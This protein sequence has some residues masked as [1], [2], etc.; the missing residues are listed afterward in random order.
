MFRLGFVRSFNMGSKSAAKADF[1]NDLSTPGQLQPPRFETLS[2]GVN[3]NRNSFL[4]ICMAVAVLTAATAAAAQGPTR[5]RDLVPFYEDVR[6]GACSTTMSD[7]GLITANTPP[8]T[9][10]FNRTFRGQPD[11]H[12]CDPILNP[13]N[14]QMTL[15]QYNAV[16]GRSAVKC[17]RNG[18]HSVLAFR[19]LRPNGVY[20]IWIVIPDSVP[21]PPIGVG[22]LG[23][24]GVNENGFVATST[25]EGQIGRTPEE[26]LSI[27]GHVGSCMLDSPFLFE[28]VYHSDG[29]THGGDP[30][31][32]N[33]W[34]TNARFFYP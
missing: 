29:M 7:V 24:T 12:F 4:A 16:S 9:L 22:G 23:R 3:M 2:T 34:V 33:T 17:I 26:D 1:I 32:P 11:P 28:L 10:L 14:S 31:P 19:G 15:G 8:N 21:G 30:G 18:T 25:G 6:G 5:D 20:T 27:F 13:D